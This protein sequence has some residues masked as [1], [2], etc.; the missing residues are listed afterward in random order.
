MSELREVP[1]R[2]IDYALWERILQGD[3]KAKGEIILR[4]RELVE[5]LARKMARNLPQHVDVSDLISY[6]VLGLMRAVG[7]YDPSRGVNFETFAAASI[8]SVIL[9]ELRKLDWAPRSLR[10]KQ[11]DLKVAQDNL[12]EELG[13][14]PTREEVAERLDCEVGEISTII[15]KS[16]A[17]YHRSLD[18]GDPE[19]DWIGGGL[20]LDSGAGLRQIEYAMHACRDVIRQMPVI[21]QVVLV[22]RYFDGMKLAA[23]GR[24]LGI[25]ESRASQIHARA[26]LGV[27]TQLIRLL[28]TSV[29]DEEAS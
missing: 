24:E 26:V 23:V 10:K 21:D 29:T 11:R 16:E 5:R 13:R 12:R 17:S 14:E 15:S 3:E 9:D 7:R 27:K 22:L 20:S 2:D 19:R 28:E 18:E 1:G 4:N 6:G 25:T 8:R